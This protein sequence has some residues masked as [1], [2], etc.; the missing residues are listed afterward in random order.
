MIT[1][2]APADVESGRRPVVSKYSASV[3]LVRT[4]T[5]V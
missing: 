2:G 1:P 4:T 3:R 5:V